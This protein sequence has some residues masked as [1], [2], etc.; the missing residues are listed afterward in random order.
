M[1]ECESSPS[2]SCINSACISFT[3]PVGGIKDGFDVFVV[4]GTATQVAGNSSSHFRLTRFYPPYCGVPVN[5][6]LIL[7]DRISSMDIFS[8]LR[9]SSPS[10]FS[11]TSCT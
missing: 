2:F 11:M 6:I 5:S 8:R 10:S 1:A 9:Y 7:P 4:A 3:K